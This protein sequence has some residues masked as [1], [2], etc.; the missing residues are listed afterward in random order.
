MEPTV[1]EAAVTTGGTDNR[2]ADL[3]E[4]EVTVNIEATVDEGIPAE[5]EAT[6]NQTT[7]TGA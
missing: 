7:S 3:M 2:E 5:T 1:N 6:V 4:V